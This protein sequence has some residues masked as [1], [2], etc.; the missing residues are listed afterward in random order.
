MAIDRAPCSNHNRRTAVDLYRK[1]GFT[2]WQL[3]QFAT[4]SDGFAGVELADPARHLVG[5]LGLGELAPYNPGPRKMIRRGTPV[6]KMGDKGNRTVRRALG[7]GQ[8]VAFS[9]LRTWPTH[10]FAGRYR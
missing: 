1:P 7:Q 8:S 2:T 4:P 10:Q 9:F 5:A 3:E 6:T